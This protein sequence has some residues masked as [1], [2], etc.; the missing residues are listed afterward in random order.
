MKSQVKGLLARWYLK[1]TSFLSKMKLKFKPGSANTVADTLSRATLPASSQE[2]GRVM[3]LSQQAMETSEALLYQIQ[4]QQKQEPELAGLYSY[5]KTRTLPKD[6]QLAKVISNLVR[7]GYFLV[8]DVL[9]Y[10]EPDAPDKRRVVVLQHLK[11]RI[12]DETHDA[13]YAGHF[14]VKKITQCISQYLYWSGM[15]G[16]IYKKCASCVTCAS[17]GGKGPRERPTLISIP[18]GGPF[19]CIGMNFVE[20][21]RSTDGNQYALAIQDYLTK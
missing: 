8:D 10:E 4:Q 17:V 21:D 20:M 12:I 1:L 3:R 13:A 11:K 14:S 18:V 6:P 19:E 5:L 7:K 2:E 16:D 9:Y 15:K